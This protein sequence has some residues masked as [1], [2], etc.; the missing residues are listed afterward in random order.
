MNKTEIKVNRFAAIDIGT[1]AIRLL[2]MNIIDRDDN[3]K[4]IF[5]KNNLVRIPIRLGEDVF[6][7]GKISEEKAGK[8]FNSMKGF[9][10]LIEANDVMDYRVCATSAMREAENGKDVVESIK[11]KTGFNLNIIDG[12]E[13][14]SII[15]STQVAEFL[16]PEK[17]Y[18]YTDV[19]GGSTDI[20]I[21]HN[22]EMIATE[23]FNIGTVRILY[24]KTE[25]EEWE[26]M[27]NW[28]KKRADDMKIDYVIGSGGNINKMRKLIETKKGKTV[29]YHQLKE[30]RN[31]LQDFTYKERI[32]NL[33][34][35]TDR[36]DVII[37]A[38]DIFL[39][40]LKWGEVKK[41]Y[42]PKIGLVDGIIHKLYDAY[43]V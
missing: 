22:H 17:I 9:R 42:A 34:L 39:R 37:P 32:V 33:N 7:K 5:K 27:K 29:T 18:M 26:R 14:A 8:L 6:V 4:P 35:K 16:D 31:Y 20:S 19:G 36:S 1:N 15:F 38:A 41:V 10:Y 40:V 30:L 13:E 24:D 28:L 12:K 21:F 25:S 43:K 11:N 2:L 23:S 3:K